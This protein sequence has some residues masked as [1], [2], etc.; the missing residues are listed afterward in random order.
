MKIGECSLSK[1]LEN[2]CYFKEEQKDIKEVTIPNGVEKIN[3]NT[4]KFCI[5]LKNVIIPNNVKY[6]GILAL[7]NC[8]SLEKY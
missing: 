1:N 3:L 5:N 4:F 2:V 6:I 7:S 8:S